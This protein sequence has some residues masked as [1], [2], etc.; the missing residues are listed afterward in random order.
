MLVVGDR[1]Q[2]GGAVAVRSHTDGDVGAESVAEFAGRI[3]TET[4]VS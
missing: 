1:E 2:E 4:A 3:E